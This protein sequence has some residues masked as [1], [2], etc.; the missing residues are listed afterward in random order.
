MDTVERDERVM[1][2][3]AEALTRPTSDRDSFL[4]EACKNDPLLYGEVAD[5]V[6][7]EERMQS[8]LRRP[9][10]EFIDFEALE[11]PFAPGQT[12]S[13]RFEILRCVGDGGMG[14]VYEAYDQKRGQRIAI[15]C[16][17]PGFGRLLKP[18]LEGALK[19]R[20]PNI[21]MVNEIHTASTDLGELDFLTMEFLDGETLAAR[22]ARGRLDHTEALDLA[23]QICAGLAAAHES[24]ILHRDLKPGNVILCPRKDGGTRLV[25]TDFGLATENSVADELLGGTPDYMAPELMREEP[26][27]QASDVFSLG[28]ILYEMATGRK[29]F[30]GRTAGN[31]VAVPPPAPGKL[32]KGLP[33]RWDDA[34][35]PCLKDD[36][37]DRGSANTT[38]AR[39]AK[40]PIYRRPALAVALAACLAL[41]VA[42]APALVHY[43]T[44]PAVRLA[45]LPVDAPDAMSQTTTSMMDDVAG[46]LRSL[47]AGKPTVAVIGIQATSKKGVTS[48]VNAQ[49]ALHATHV[50]KLKVLPE[51]DGV[52]VEGALV[53]VATLAHVGDYIAHFNSGDLGDLPGGLAESV[54]RSLH[55]HRSPPSETLTGGALAAYQNGREHLNR[56][57]ASAGEAFGLFEEAAGM[58][59][60]SPLPLAGAAEAKVREYQAR[61]DERALQE[62]KLWL[63]RANALDADSPTVLLASGLLN[64]VEGRNVAA[65]EDYQRV[66]EMEP[67]NVEALLGSG[68]SYE[69]QHQ[70]E[71]ALTAYHQAAAAAPQFYK[72]YEY[73]GGFYY[74]QGRY[75]EAEEPFRQDVERDPRRLGGYGSLAAVYVAQFKYA[76]AERTFRASEEL[77]DNA[78]TLN[79]IGAML[80][81]QHRDGEAIGYY[82]RALR[83]APA[84]YIYWLN[85]GDSQRRTGQTAQARLAYLK[86]Q[87]LALDQVSGNPSG[88]SARAYLAYLE[89]RLGKKSAAEQEAAAALKLAPGDNQVILCAVQTYEVLGDRDRALAAAGLATPQILKELDNHPDLADFRQDSRFKLMLAHSK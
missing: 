88:G 20:H 79:N 10:V 65:L 60:H 52:K 87:N 63:A 31:G 84:S 68:L 73:I 4:R 71:R 56:E 51:P 72:P 14:V 58:A 26:A 39:L 9:L 86:G 83:L 12:I 54:S 7:W 1:T 57:D 19:V 75:A 5:I 37:K 80:A 21:C 82:E 66:L 6:A 13:S 41:A 62:A 70:P 28:A 34:I 32:V 15:K 67:A 59:P 77:R 64:Q 61:Q 55:L 43:F 33:A 38:L 17:K 3:A 53:D 48:A 11:K 36:P 89:S 50:L 23:R 45:I 35:L 25:I 81:Y 29:P 27:S 8:F 42:V 16:A 85:L 74:Y 2:L 46:R 30:P 47:Q 69:M 44:P 22:L 40:A 78:L 18:E 76:E 49:R 24:N